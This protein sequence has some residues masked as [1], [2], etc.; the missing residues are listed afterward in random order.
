MRIWYGYSS[1]HSTG[2]TIIATFKTAEAMAA[3]K[4]KIEHY[5]S[6]LKFSSPERMSLYTPFAKTFGEGYSAYEGKNNKMIIDTD[7]FV[8]S[9][10]IELLLSQNAEI[11]ISGESYPLEE[12]ELNTPDLRE[13][14]EKA[15]FWFDDMDDY[16]DEPDGH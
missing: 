7:A 15:G 3:V 5:D 1:E 10:M 16:P 8:Y 9:T 11:K 2:M 14:A 13:C 4:E 12:T 6:K